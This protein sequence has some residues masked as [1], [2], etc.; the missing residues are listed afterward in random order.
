MGAGS[1]TAEVAGYFVKAGKDVVDIGI[2]GSLKDFR[3][4]RRRF[5]ARNSLDGLVEVVEESALDFV[6]Q[7][8]AV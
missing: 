4:A 5:P 3:Y 8:T 1:G 6:G 7:P 2:G